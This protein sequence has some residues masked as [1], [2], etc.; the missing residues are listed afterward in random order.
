MTSCVDPKY[1]MQATDRKTGICRESR[2][3]AV[4]C[5]G[6]E[7]QATQV[8]YINAELL[9]LCFLLSCG[10]LVPRDDLC[11]QPVRHG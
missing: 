4:A 8:M 5:V 10:G 1:N 7:C 9:V 11:G 3:S 2:A 6:Y